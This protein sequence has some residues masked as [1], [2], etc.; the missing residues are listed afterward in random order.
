MES[1]EHRIVNGL[2]REL[3][4]V[5]T[6]E[7]AEELLSRNVE[8]CLGERGKDSDDLWPCV[9]AL[10]VA[11]SKQFTGTV[12]LN[13]PSAD[14]MSSP[15][16]LSERVVLGEPGSTEVIRIGVGVG[17]DEGPF[18]L[19]G[20]TRGNRISF[21]YLLDEGHGVANPIGCFALAGYLGFAVLARAV[22]IA[23]FAEEYVGNILEMP[24]DASKAMQLPSDG[25][26]FLGLG[27]LGQAYLALLFFLMRKYHWQPRV[28]LLDKDRFEP[29]NEPTQM[30]LEAGEPWSGSEKSE[31]VGAL[32][33]GWGLEVTSRSTTLDWTFKRAEGV[34][35]LALLGFDNF[36]ARRIAINGGFDWI[37]EGGIGTSLAKP[38]VTWHSLSPRNELV[39]HLFTGRAEYREFPEKDFLEA[40]KRTPGQCGWFSFKNVDAS[41]PTMGLVAA[42]YVWAETKSVCE[43]RRR[44][45]RGMGYVWPSVL[46]FRREPLSQARDRDAAA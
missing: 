3:P 41:A 36:E 26:A 18:D 24:F 16:G 42:A 6:P 43:G 44:E 14:K 15:A 45:V 29:A 19:Y 13:F 34:P 35:S 46:P 7:V 30:L 12:F 28:F 20:D 25:I 32:V 17:A 2:L 39:R 38:R 11:L 23:T 8:I 1:Y 37:V 40:L 27:Q 9:W 22:G 31:Y 33:R 21:G 4:E 10:A 5:A